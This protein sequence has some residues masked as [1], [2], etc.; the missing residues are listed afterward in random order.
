M[1]EV[2]G[3]GSL[4]REVDHYACMGKILSVVADRHASAASSPPMPSSSVST[5]SGIG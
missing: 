2:S 1:P 3:A 4:I 5:Y